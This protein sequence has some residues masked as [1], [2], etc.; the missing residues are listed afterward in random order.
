[1]VE[2]I[3]AVVIRV[4]DEENTVAIVSCDRTNKID[5]TYKMRAALVRALTK[6]VKKTEEG[7]YLYEDNVE[8]LNVGDL[9][10]CY[11]DETL[12]P[13]LVKH[14]IHNLQVHVENDLEPIGWEF[15]DK[16]VED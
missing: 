12:K 16:L 3:Q 5:T 6:W 4:S 10:S 11:E 9:W 7:G 14:G 1:M 15:D 2:R 8:D 13:F